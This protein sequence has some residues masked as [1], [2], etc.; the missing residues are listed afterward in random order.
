MGFWNKVGK[1]A[2]T[3]LE[4]GP[5][6]LSALAEEGAKK[7]RQMYKDAEHKMK[8][9]EGRIS[10]AE[11]SDKM[12]NPEYAKKVNEAK[13]KLEN[14]KVKMYSDNGSSD[15]VKVNPNGQ[16]T[17]AGKT[18]EQ[19]EGQ[20]RNLG[21]L[22]SLTLNDLSPYNHSVGLYKAVI[23]GKIYYIGRAIEYNNGGFRKRLRD[24]VR[25]SD[26]ART[27]KSG[28]K[29]NENADMIQ[30]S[31]L[32]V[33]DTEKDVETTKQLERAFIMKYAPQW[34]VQFNR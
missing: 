33:G 2:T 28:G 32:V 7:Q 3:L 30:I 8:E 25:D 19:W 34:N 23:G 17:M 9:Y 20:W 13:Q 14:V 18:I 27:H 24:Y 16:V 11:K 4:E 6:L 31:I 10:S 1:I 15:A 5:E 26:S 22:S 12:S 29:M 21:I